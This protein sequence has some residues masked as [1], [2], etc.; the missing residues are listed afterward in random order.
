MVGCHMRMLEL[1]MQSTLPGGGNAAE[2]A[3]AKAAMSPA[4]R[5]G[6]GKAA[7]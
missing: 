3:A 4:K 5:S 1:P 2:S 7:E 6:S